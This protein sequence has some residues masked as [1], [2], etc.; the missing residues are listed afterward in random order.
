M[1][2]SS[3]ILHFTLRIL[4]CFMAGCASTRANKSEFAVIPISNQHVAQLSADDVVRVMRRAGFSDE[5]IIELG[6]QLRDGLL[7]S[8]AVQISRNKIVESIF[9][10]KDNKVHIFARLRGNFIY[11]L[12][13]GNFVIFASPSP[14]SQ[15]KQ[16]Q[17]K[18]SP[19][20]TMPGIL[21]QQSTLPNLSEKQSQSKDIW[22]RPRQ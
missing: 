10:V 11:D 22:Q 13:Q 6:T 3:K 8:G 15:P 16:S 14:Q 21:H 2:K 9:A 19:A 7:R 1:K 5:Q 18:Q 20:T 12:Q 17:P 4:L